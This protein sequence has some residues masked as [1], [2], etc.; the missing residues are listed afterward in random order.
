MWDTQPGSMVLALVPAWW[1][2]E[3]MGILPL[4]RPATV[5]VRFWSAT[6]P[7]G[8]WLRPGRCMS[9]DKPCRVT[10]GANEVSADH[11]LAR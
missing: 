2:L 5:A 9:C 3:W 8:S 1:R 6:S 10:V 4:P 7:S 11:Q